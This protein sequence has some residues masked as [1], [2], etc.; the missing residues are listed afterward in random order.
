VKLVDISGT[1][2]RNILKLKLMNFKQTVRT[3]ISDT[4][5]GASVTLRRGSSP[6]IM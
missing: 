2:T 6:E 4:F 3:R 1:K 5:T